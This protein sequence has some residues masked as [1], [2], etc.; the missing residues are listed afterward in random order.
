MECD[1]FM[2]EKERVGAGSPFLSLALLQGM[3]V[4][5]EGGERRR[6]IHV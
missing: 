6:P 2:P 4:K 1:F 5:A 3:S